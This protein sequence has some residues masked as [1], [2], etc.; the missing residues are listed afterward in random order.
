MLRA[1]C[2]RNFN[3]SSKFYPLKFSTEVDREYGR[4]DS[5]LPKRLAVG[6]RPRAKKVNVV[7]KLIKKPRERLFYL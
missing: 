6:G 5:S 4:R 3:A 2:G 7:L 1:S